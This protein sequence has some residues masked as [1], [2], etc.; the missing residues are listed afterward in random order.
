VGTGGAMDELD[1]EAPE[2]AGDASGY[3]ALESEAE[4]AHV[5]HGGRAV[6]AEP[7]VAAE[8]E[9]FL[10]LP[11]LLSPEQTALLLARR[12]HDLKRRAGRLAPADDDEP[13]P[14]ELAAYERIAATRRRLSAMVSAHSLATGR[15]HGWIHSELRRRCGGPPTPQATL[16]QLEARIAALQQW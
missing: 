3:E 1:L 12:D 9:D 6:V 10:G 13:E 7:A 5:L 16:E 8:D 15:P 14:A 4:F 2:P 11:G